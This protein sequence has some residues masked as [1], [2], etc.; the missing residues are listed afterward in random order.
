MPAPDSPGPTPIGITVGQAKRLACQFMADFEEW[1]FT[2]RLRAKYPGRWQQPVRNPVDGLVEDPLE[3]PRI[4][5]NERFTGTVLE[6]PQGWVFLFRADYP[7][8][9]PMPL[10]THEVLVVV[11][12]DA[13][14]KT[15]FGSEP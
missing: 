7:T 1:E 13:E 4:I 3:V 5:R 10:R 8:Q 2:P 12:R 9:G 11:G 6:R 15:V 14:I